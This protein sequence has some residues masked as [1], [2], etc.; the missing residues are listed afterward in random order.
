MTQNDELNARLAKI[1]RQ[2]EAKSNELRSLEAQTDAAV[3]QILDA[4]SKAIREKL[5]RQRRYNL[6][7][8]ELLRAELEVLRLRRAAAET[9][10]RL[11]E[12]ETMTFPRPPDI[13]IRG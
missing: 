2:L 13:G 1:N 6:E 9:F 11:Q 7:E 3:A 5:A 8:S 4:P 12:A 10:Q